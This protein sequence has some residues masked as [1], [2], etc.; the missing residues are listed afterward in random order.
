MNCCKSSVFLRDSLVFLKNDKNNN[1]YFSYSKTPLS[2]SIA[3]FNQWWSGLF[4]SVR[5]NNS[6]KFYATYGNLQYLP[7]KRR[8]TPG[9]RCTG[10][11]KR[12]RIEFFWHSGL[13][14]ACLKVKEKKVNK[15]LINKLPWEI[16]EILV[17]WTRNSQESVKYRHMSWYKG[18]KPRYIR[19]IKKKNINPFK[20]ECKIRPNFSN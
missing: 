6:E 9:I 17:Y 2:C 5:L 3:N 12:S 10:R 19:K 1:I 15:I 18:D 20:I 13:A 7:C 16:H 4:F 14:S 8:S 11:I